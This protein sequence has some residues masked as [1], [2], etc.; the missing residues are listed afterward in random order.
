[1]HPENKVRRSFSD[2]SSKP[3]LAQPPHAAPPEQQSRMGLYERPSEPLTNTG[4]RQPS[5][6]GEEMPNRQIMSL[7][8]QG[9]ID[10]KVTPPPPLCTCHYCA[11]RCC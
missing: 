7:G 6:W 5:F 8:G 11:G 1:L 4:S 9:M 3:P 10:E 2:P